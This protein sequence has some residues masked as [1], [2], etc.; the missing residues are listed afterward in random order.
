MPIAGFPDPYITCTFIDDENLFVCLFYNKTLTH[1]HFIY[2]DQEHK[3]V[4]EI[5]KTVLDCTMKNFPYKCFFNIEDNQ[6]YIFY[7]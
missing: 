1:Y 2:N 3:I 4:S 7:R 5:S 6:I